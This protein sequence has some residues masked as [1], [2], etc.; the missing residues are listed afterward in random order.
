MRP[1]RLPS[2]FKLTEHNRHKSF[3]YQPRTYDERK[4]RLE[5]RKKE[6]EKELALEKKLGTNYEEHLRERISDSWTRKETRRTQRNS[7]LRLLLILAAL[8]AVVLYFYN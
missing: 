4:E 7:G 1:P 5:K 6:I 2:V 8:L 3:N